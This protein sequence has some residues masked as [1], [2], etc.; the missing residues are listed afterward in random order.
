MLKLLPE[1]LKI[2]GSVAVGAIVAAGVYSLANTV[3]L[4]PAAKQQGRNEYIAEQAV[5]DLKA[6]RERRKSDAELQKMSDYD[7]CVRALGGVPGC[8]VFRVQ[9]IR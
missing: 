5:A 7:L 8:D 9:P 4:L 2:G 6:E 1:W 3:W